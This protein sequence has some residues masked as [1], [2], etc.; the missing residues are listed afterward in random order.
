MY[1]LLFSRQ[2]F[3]FPGFLAPYMRTQW[4]IFSCTTGCHCCTASEI[5]PLRSPQHRTRRERARSRSA[6]QGRRGARSPSTYVCALLQRFKPAARKPIWRNPA[7]VVCTACLSIHQEGISI[8][9]SVT[10]AA[11]LGSGTC[12]AGTERGERD[13]RTHIR[14]NTRTHKHTRTKVI[15]KDSYSHI[16]FLYI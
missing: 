7:G 12:C 14:T 6:A 4:C 2:Y 8:F 5:V 3:P 16:D 13:T 9:Q 11:A 1:S 15:L 10:N